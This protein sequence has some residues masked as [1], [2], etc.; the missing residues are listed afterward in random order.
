MTETRMK[1]T[2][3]KSGERVIQDPNVTYQRIY[4]IFYWCINVGA[5]SLVATVFME[6]YKGFWTVNLLG[7]LGFLLGFA[8][9]LAGKKFYVVRPPQGSIL[10][11]AFKAMWIGLVNGRSM[12]A[13]RP[14][15]QAG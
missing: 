13:A 12:E 7:L 15:Y 2:T 14:S 1:I 9:L 8:V 11:H 3:T 6:K 5:L 4:L 10:P